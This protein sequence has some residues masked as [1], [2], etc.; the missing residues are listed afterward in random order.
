MVNQ[1]SPR[2]TSISQSHSHSH[3]H[4]RGI[5]KKKMILG[6]IAAAFVIILVLLICILSASSRNKKYD[7]DYQSAYRSYVT[8]EYDDALNYAQKALYI[9]GLKTDQQEKVYL[10]MADI[11]VGK[12]DPQSAKDLISKAY[13]ELGT[14]ALAEKLK[15]LGAEPGTG[16]AAGDISIGNTTVKKD[17]TSAVLSSM[18]LT[19]ADIAPLAGATALQTLTL[20]QNKLSDIS[21][22]AGLTSLTYLQLA[23]NQITDLSP[24]KGLTNLRTLY[25]DKNPITDLTPLYSMQSL[26]LLSLNGVALT[27][28]QLKDL[29]DKLPNC[30]IESDQEAV[31]A[32]LTMGGQTF[33]TTVTDLSLVNCNITDISDLAYCKDLTSLDLQ[34]NS[35][36]D[37]SALSGLTKLT[38]L[39]LWDNNITDI[40]P[41]SSLT[42]LTYLDLDDNNVK[43]LTPLQS[44]TNLTQLWVERQTPL[45]ISPIANLTNLTRLGLR[46]TGLKSS[47]L[48]YLKG[49]TKLTELRL[50]GNNNLT[51]DAL[52]ALKKALPNCTITAPD[53]KYT[54]KLGG[55]TYDSD[56]T[57]IK[58]ERASITDIS[59]LS[60]FTKLTDLDLAGN[61]I[62]DISVLSACTGLKTLNISGNSVSDLSALSKLTK[63][64]S[65]NLSGNKISNISSLY[66]LQNLRSLDVTNTGLTWDQVQMLQVSLPSCTVYSNVTEPTMASTPAPTPETTPI[67]TEAS[68]SNT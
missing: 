20:S 58:C 57:Y 34:G 21:A 53:V 66:G 37:I 23:E 27:S 38:R 45:T 24:L 22:L 49:L 29:H 3:S 17:A 8:E 30:S 28:D 4:S 67:P 10:L 65:L 15:Q 35:I 40:G 18:N 26:T 61:G 50:D 46:N 42:A 43:D 62:K 1:T 9:H 63:L 31:P 7:N 47:D 13:K 68:S 33:S 12:G 44:L 54:I 25:L 39:V 2:H 48:G 56:T 41:L 14:D 11:Y 55:T 64:T 52:D 5:D 36:T 16:D 32:E 60:H 59:A 51:G 6:G 19:S